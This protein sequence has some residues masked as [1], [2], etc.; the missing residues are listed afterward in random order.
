MLSELFA[1][2]KAMDFKKANKILGSVDFLDVLINPWVIAVIAIVCVVL[3]IRRGLAA[4]VTFLSFPA[5]MV[6]F[7]Q[8][9]QGSKAVELEYSVTGLLIFVGGFL[10]IA[11]INIYLH[12]VR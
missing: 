7:Q 9:V 12:F 1:A 2:L 11:G 4:V 5:L 8:T 6:L 10:A 3:A